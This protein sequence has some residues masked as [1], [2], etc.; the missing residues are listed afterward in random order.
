MRLGCITFLSGIVVSGLSVFLWRVGYEI[1]SI[2]IGFFA[3][4][5]FVWLAV[6]ISLWLRP[7]G[8]PKPKDLRVQTGALLE[9]YI[10]GVSGHKTEHEHA[11]DENESIRDLPSL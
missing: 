5:L 8:F 1:M 11:W 10:P 2:L 4:C 3:F 6:Q 7:R 9:R